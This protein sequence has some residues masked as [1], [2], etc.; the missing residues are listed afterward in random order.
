MGTKKEILV[1]VKQSVKEV[2]INKPRVRNALSANNALFMAEAIEN[3]EK[4]GTRAVLITGKGGAFCAGADLGQE[5]QAMFG[6]GSVH[7]EAELDEMLETTYHRLARAIYS[8]P[9]PV[10]AAVGGVAAGFGC[11]LA[12]NADI[13]LASTDARFIQV[14]RNIALIPDGGSTYILPRLIG[15]KKA[16]EMILTGEPVSAEKAL[17]WNMVNHLYPPEEL[18]D[19]ARQWALKLSQGPTKTLGM[20]KR[21]V[22]EAQYMDYRQVLA[23]EGR[24]QARL[25]TK[26]DFFNAVTAFFEKKKPSFS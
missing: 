9:M 19:Q 6:S 13:T 5:A 20:A 25:M 2:T 14:F 26:P 18:M 17:E 8:L 23:M 16:M 3:S 21:T 15:V 24:R 11:S 12:L 4:D 1:S 7:L 10:I 22:Y